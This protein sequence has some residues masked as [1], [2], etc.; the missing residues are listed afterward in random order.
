MPQTLEILRYPDPRLRNKC[1]PVEGFGPSLRRFAERML[2]AM[3]ASNGI[4]L[5]AAQ[6][7]DPRRIIVID[8]SEERND[9]HIFVNPVITARSGSNRIEEGCLSVPGIHAEVERSD[10]IAFE[11]RSPEGHHRSAKYA[12]LMAICVQ[13][14]IDHL[15]GRLFVD[16]LPFTQRLRAWFIARNHR[17]AQPEPARL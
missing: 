17:H 11:Y 8:L 4:G 5:A 1:A 7:G 16:Y 6:V 10:K 13:H 3:Y 15:D 14:E 12:G 2:E 9:P